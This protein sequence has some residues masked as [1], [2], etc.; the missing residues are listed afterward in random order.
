MRLTTPKGRSGAL[1]KHQRLL[2]LA[3][4]CDFILGGRNGSG[5]VALV[6]IT[7]PLSLG[8]PTRVCSLGV[9]LKDGPFPHGG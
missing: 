5:R 2:K 6:R 3:R 8:V 1:I 4:R 7:G 9:G